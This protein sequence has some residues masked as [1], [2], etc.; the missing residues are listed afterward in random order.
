MISDV[1][2][3][4]RRTTPLR[5]ALD[6]LPLQHASPHVDDRQPEAI[7]PADRDIVLQGLEDLRQGEIAIDEEV[8]AAFARFRRRRSS[9]R[10]AP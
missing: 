2:T 6:P 5:R 3:P 8:R 9:S 7:D 4:R 10:A 1:R